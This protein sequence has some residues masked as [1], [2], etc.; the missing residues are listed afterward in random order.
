[1]LNFETD[2]MPFAIQILLI[3]KIYE[4]SN[5]VEDSE[6]NA[7]FG[8]FQNSQTQRRKNIGQIGL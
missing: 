2:V 3:N 1:M 8:T 6:P 5:K 4:H 7:N